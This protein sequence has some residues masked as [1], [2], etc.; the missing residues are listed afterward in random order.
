MELGAEKSSPKS[1][2][3]NQAKCYGSNKHKARLVVKGY[4]QIF[5]VNYSDTLGP[6]ARLDTNRL[7]FAV[8]AQ[9]GWNEEIHVEQPVGFVKKGE[10][11]KLKM[12]KV[13]EMTNLGLTTYFLGVEI[14]QS[15][16]EVSI[17]QKKYAKQILKKF[18]M[19]DCKLM[20]TPMNQK[21]K[22][23]KEDGTE[24]S[25]HCASEIQL[26]AARRVIR[27]IKDAIN[28]GIKFKKSKEFKLLGFSKVTRQASKSK[29]M[30][31][32]HGKQGGR[33]E[34]QQVIGI[35][36]SMPTHSS[37]LQQN[38]NACKLSLQFLTER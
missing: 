7:L 35:E 3:L 22:F 36:R 21:K 10:E 5:G 19:E 32:K 31:M 26:K 4:A 37:Q 29:I 2:K 1:T 30:G 15:Q 27:Y 23:N 14:K 38:T 9:M 16:D 17:C 11:D 20:N 13:F 25:M 12:T 33:E 18:H 6:M 34:T 24:K 28:F 8:A